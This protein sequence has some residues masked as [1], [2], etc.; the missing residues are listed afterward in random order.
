VV[1][2]IAADVRSRWFYLTMGALVDQMSVSSNLILLQCLHI[3]RFSQHQCS[4]DHAI[5]PWLSAF[6]YAP[7]QARLT[8]K[9]GTT[10]DGLSLAFVFLVDVCNSDLGR[11]STRFPTRRSALREARKTG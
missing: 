11:Y 1:A 4:Q 10:N 8:P 9:N 6:S 2:S 7:F 5:L 3:V